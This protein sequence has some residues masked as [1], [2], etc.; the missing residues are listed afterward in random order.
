[1][2][3][4]GHAGGGRGRGAMRTQ[5]PHGERRE[6]RESASPILAEATLRV[7]RATESIGLLI[8][9]L[10][11]SRSAVR[12]DP[13]AL[14]VVATL[15]DPASQIQVEM[16]ELARRLDGARQA[17]GIAD[18]EVAAPRAEPE[19]LA[20]PPSEGIRLLVSQMT[21]EG[22]SRDQIAARLRGRFGVAAAEAVVDHVLGSRSR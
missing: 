16:G 3:I 5:D 7:E 10:E 12:D 4:L 6:R 22:A 2:P 8:E 13:E 14:R 18:V 17:L 1:M 20:E 11:R 19:R 21:R 9:D 15:M